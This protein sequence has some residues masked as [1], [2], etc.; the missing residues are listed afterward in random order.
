ML[1]GKG[2]AA[3]RGNRW[4]SQYTPMVYT[5]GSRSLAILEVLSHVDLFTDL[6]SDRLLVEIEI[7][8]TIA[9]KQITIEQLPNNWNIY[10]PIHFT[11]ILGDEFIRL[12]E[13]T[14]LQVPS[15]LVNGEF[16]YLI[17]PKLIRNNQIKIIQAE[18]L[19]LERWRR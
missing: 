2:A 7:S 17:N 13:F 11:R 4:N 12:A 19:K 18:S 8:D 9:F 10:P 5:S 14:I 6:P 3:S 16:N 1:Q 15:S